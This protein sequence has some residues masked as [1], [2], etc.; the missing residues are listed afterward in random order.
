MSVHVDSAAEAER[1]FQ[2]LADGGRVLTAIE[3]TFWA[4][5]FGMV[6]DRFGVSWLIN[7]SGQ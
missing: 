5:R 7:A 4:E 1:I 6:V 3:K 2:Q